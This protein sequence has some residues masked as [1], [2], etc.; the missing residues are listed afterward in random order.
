[1]N[2]NEYIIIIANVN[3]IGVNHHTNKKSFKSNVNSLEYR[4]YVDPKGNK[5]KNSTVMLIT[6]ILVL[7]GFEVF[8][9]VG[10]QKINSLSSHAGDW[11]TGET[12]ENLA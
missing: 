9:N 12:L 10:E 11:K 6:S 4:Y 2:P 8:A 5:E 7:E 3:V 1:M